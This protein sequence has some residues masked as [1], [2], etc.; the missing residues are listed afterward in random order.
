MGLKINKNKIDLYLKQNSISKS[1]R[2]EN[3]K[4]YSFENSISS[5]TNKILSKIFESTYNEDN[6]ASM[7]KPNDLFNKLSLNL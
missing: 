4:L 2:N 6:N 5:F 7:I 3:E 1:N